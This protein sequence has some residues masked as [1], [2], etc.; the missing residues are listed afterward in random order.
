[1]FLLKN[2]QIEI[3]EE[4]EETGKQI[5]GTTGREQKINT[6]LNKFLTTTLHQDHILNRYQMITAYVLIMRGVGVGRDR[7]EAYREISRLMITLDV[8]NKSDKKRQ[9]ILNVI[10]L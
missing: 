8:T 1:L 10:V 9:L 5:K 2:N 4:Q 6:R 7:S 3:K